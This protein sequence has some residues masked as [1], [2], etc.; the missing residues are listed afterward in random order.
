[1]AAEA[2]RWSGLR[3][4]A[5]LLLLW[6][7][8]GRL[9]LVAGGALPGLTEIL[10]RLWIDRADYPLH[11]WATLYASGLGF[12]IGNLVGIAAGV[13]F[14]LFP[15]ALRVFRGVNIAVFAL[16]PIAIAPILVLTLSGMAPRVTLAAMGVYFVTMTAT[17]IGITQA[18]SRA[19]DLIRAYGGGRWD[20]LRLVQLRGA[21]PA[22]LAGLRVAAPNAVLGAILAEFGGGG[23]WGLGTYLL[24]SLGRGEPDRLWG[25]G[26][27]ATVIAGLSY[28][29][30]ALLSRRMLGASRAVTLNAAVPEAAPAKLSPV[31]RLLLGL[32]AIAMPFLLWW[33]FIRLTGV[34]DLISKTPWGV[35]DY[36]FLGRSAESAQAR[37]LAALAET[38]PIT[39][40]GMLAGLGFAFLLAISS[41]LFPRAIAAFMP[42]ALITQTMPLVALTPLLVLILGRGT[43]LTLWVTISVTFFPAFVTLAQG[44]AL[45]PRSAE[46]LPR[47]YGASRWTEIR[48]VTI[49]ASL[50]YLFAATRL[51]V[52]RA[53]LGVMIA[54]WLATG[55]GLGNL[56]NQSRG[57][58]DYGMI[59][60]VAAVSVALS[61]L[62][63][64]IVVVIERRVLRRVG[65]SSAE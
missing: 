58:L 4:A 57:F 6:E 40:V 63:Y 55:K 56:L 23:R 5:I 22:I 41:R 24:G 21:V 51:T 16:P 59:W 38:L 15:A 45:V 54:E 60:S 29:G 39:F 35:I 65:M 53:L 34:P 49:P 27:V 37:L 8:V 43:T 10:H 30:F 50:P 25:I 47:A 64:Q 11:I 62:F 13:I 20:V 17:V 1:M 28:A 32:A 61:V 19:R 52:P 33:G 18:D 36:L 9:D 7:I 31:P 14:A 12:V 26:L 44:L 48:M 3:N 2:S 46:E 42:V